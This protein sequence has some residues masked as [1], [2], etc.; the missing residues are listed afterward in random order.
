MKYELHIGLLGFKDD[1][2]E[3]ELRILL[4]KYVGSVQPKIIS[5]HQSLL[6]RVIYGIDYNVRDEDFY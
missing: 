2:S 5:S 6:S 3:N 4:S 1:F